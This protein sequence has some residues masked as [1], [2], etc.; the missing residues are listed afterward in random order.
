MVGFLYDLQK[1]AICDHDQRLASVIYSMVSCDL[2]I[3]YYDNLQHEKTIN[4]KKIQMVADT[5][6][7]F[8]FSMTNRL[9]TLGLQIRLKLLD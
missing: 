6:E 3:R 8:S 7:M 9:R 1:S 2:N 4:I 5:G